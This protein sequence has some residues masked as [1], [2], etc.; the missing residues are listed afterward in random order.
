MKVLWVCKY[1][2]AKQSPTKTAQHKREKSEIWFD[3]KARKM[4]MMTLTQIECVCTHR[5]KKKMPLIGWHTHIRTTIS[6]IRYDDSLVKTGLKLM[7]ASRV[8]RL[9]RS[10]K[11]LM[12][13]WAWRKRSAFHVQIGIT[14]SRVDLMLHHL[15]LSAFEHD[16]Q[17]PCEIKFVGNAIG[18]GVLE[19][20]CETIKKFFCSRFTKL[21][22]NGISGLSS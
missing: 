16:E 7:L 2:E 17:M 13:N 6:S 20:N 4:T 15:L 12:F 18:R 9:G 8:V 10:T 14:I 22:Q 11:R 1:C 19:R 21:I 5:E 3:D